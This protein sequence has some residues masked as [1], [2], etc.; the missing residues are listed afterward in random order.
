MTV[1]HLPD[2]AWRSVLSAPRR[3][4]ALR[5]QRLGEEFCDIE[6]DRADLGML[7]GPR[8]R[9]EPG[10]RWLP[11]KEAFSP[12][13]VR[14]VLDQLSGLEG[15]LL[16]MFAGSATS[17][18]VAA[19]RG[20]DSVGVELLPY[21]QW[22]A[23][24]VVRAHTADHAIFRNAVRVAADAADPRLIGSP[25]GWQVPAASW[26]VSGEVGAVLL[27]LREALPPRGSGIEA[28]LAH[29]ALVSVVEPVS[30]SVKDGTSL[31]H[32]DRQRKGRTTRPGRKG[33]QITR[34]RGCPG[35]CG[36]GQRDRQ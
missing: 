1:Q 17:L 3:G 35:L 21:A 26:A 4:D 8:R 27:A 22:A 20:L 10:Y 30:M 11:Y 12:G 29:L 36:R 24:A 2:G 15:V 6:R 13:L 34:R 19:E 18:L 5:I 7:A 25:L 33:Q 32:R 31:R 14:A 28:D 16:D 23:D 9:D